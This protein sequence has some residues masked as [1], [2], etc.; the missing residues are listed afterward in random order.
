MVSGIVKVRL[1]RIALAAVALVA[2]VSGCVQVQLNSSVSGATLRIAAVSS[3]QT[4]LAEQQTTTPVDAT[5]L[6]GLVDWQQ[7]NGFEQLLWEYAEI[8]TFQYMFNL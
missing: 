3:P 4:I 1:C 2:V 8:C 7:L 6:L 5:V